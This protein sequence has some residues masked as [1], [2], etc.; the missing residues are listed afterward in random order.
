M[1]SQN[2]I[3]M[4]IKTITLIVIAALLIGISLSLFSRYPGIQYATAAI[5]AMVALA[6][7]AQSYFTGFLAI[8]TKMSLDLQILSGPFYSHI[9][10]S[11][12]T[13][14]LVSRELDNIL[15][16]GNIDTQRLKL[17][18][19]GEPHTDHAPLIIER[20][21]R[22]EPASTGSARG[23]MIY[24]ARTPK[25]KR[26][27]EILMKAVSITDHESEDLVRDLRKASQLT[28]S[29]ISNIDLKKDLESQIRELKKVID[30][31]SKKAEEKFY[32]PIS[33]PILEDF[34]F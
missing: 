10:A 12:I 30:R 16:S 24:K 28:N 27:L 8:Q 31:I 4:K 17:I 6:I 22:P 19:E 25:L 29:L 13:L 5:N 15:K 20:Y 32:V 26:S 33:E 2:D 34:S 11:L 9:A 14:R 18:L 1:K 7:I 3:D 21:I 23:A